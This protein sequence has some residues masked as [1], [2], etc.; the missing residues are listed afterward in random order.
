[1]RWKIVTAAIFATGWVILGIGAYQ[2]SPSVLWVGIGI[3]MAGGLG[4]SVVLS[5][6]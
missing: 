4:L 6:R 5:P 3:T 2:G 1:M